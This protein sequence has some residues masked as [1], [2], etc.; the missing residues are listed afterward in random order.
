MNAIAFSGVAGAVMGSWE[1][2]RGES[3]QA[4]AVQVE[5]DQSEVRAE[6]VMVPR[7]ASVSHLVE[8]EDAFQD[9]GTHVLI[10]LLLSISSC[11]SF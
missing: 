5:I 7:D 9:P 10:W 1:A 3:C 2:L 4:L 8:A 11:S 6:S